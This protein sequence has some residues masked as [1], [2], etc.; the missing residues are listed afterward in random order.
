MIPGG[1]GAAAGR[2]T[3]ERTCRCPTAPQSPPHVRHRGTAWAAVIRAGDPAR[4]VARRRPQRLR[5]RRARAPDRAAAPD[6]RRRNPTGPC[7]LAGD[8]RAGGRRLRLLRP[9]SPIAR[10]RA[11]ASAPRLRSSRGTP[12]CRG[13]GPGLPRRSTSVK[14]STPRWPE[15]SQRP[16]CAAVRTA[17]APRSVRPGSRDPDRSRGTAPRTPR[18]PGGRIDPARLPG[19]GCCG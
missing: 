11:E 1:R 19:R 9:C 4:A 16:F 18:L 3:E 2:R 14:R 12:A 7:P 8:Q 15:R 13:S 5:A 10:H 17:R 6:P